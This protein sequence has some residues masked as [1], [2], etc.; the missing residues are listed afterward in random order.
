MKMVEE[1]YIS[2]E[3]G[4]SSKIS[5]CREAMSAKIANGK[6]QTILTT[7]YAKLL[8]VT[9]LGCMIQV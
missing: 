1:E 4:L 5:K 7:S 9:A 8:F 6:Q 2:F 3:D